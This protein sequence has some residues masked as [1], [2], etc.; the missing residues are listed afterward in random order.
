MK[1]LFSAE[2]IS[3]EG[4]LKTNQAPSGLQHA[5]LGSLHDGGPSV[6]GYAWLGQSDQSPVRG[7]DESTF[8]N[9][10]LG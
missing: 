2:T 3:K 1:N 7:H 9:S 6:T 5:P 8:M 10:Q 4:H